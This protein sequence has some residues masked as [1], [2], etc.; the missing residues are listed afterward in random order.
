MF[1]HFSM[2]VCSQNFVRIHK[3]KNPAEL[4]TKYLSP[5]LMIIHVHGPTNY[6]LLLNYLSKIKHKYKSD[7]K[8][9]CE[10][11]F[12]RYFNFKRSLMVNSLISIDK[13]PLYEL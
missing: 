5:S 2:F 11:I 1:Q 9:N 6:F 4:N 7:F 8:K 12:L 3:N 13:S 10:D